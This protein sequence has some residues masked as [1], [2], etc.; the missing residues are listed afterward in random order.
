MTD[1][2]PEIRHSHP[3]VMYDM[4]K[5]IPK[6]IDGT[7]KK[8]EPFEGKNFPEPLI[9]TG[10]GTAYHSAVLG[11]QFL[12]RSGVKWDH[13]QAYELMHYREP[14][15]SIMAFS[16]TGKTKSTVDV[17]R[18][19]RKK[20][21]TVGITHYPE[22]PLAQEAHVAF[23]IGN[24]P[25]ASLCNTKAFF[26]NVFAS[27]FISNR[28]GNLGLDLK[29]YR[30]AISREIAGKEERVRAIVKDLS[31]TRDI[32]VLGAGPNYIAAREA[33]QKM[34]E[35]TH[36]HAEGIELEEFNHGCTAV[37]DEN[38]TVFII[39]GE[40]DEERTSDIVRACREVGTRT[41]VLNS[42]GDY[43]IDVDFIG[44]NL[45]LPIISMVDL[46]YFAYF[47]AVERGINPD[48]LRF[49]DKRYLNFDSIVFPPGT[50]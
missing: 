3:Y 40:R 32:F 19:Y 39:S 17:V 8:M 12:S 33:A 26:D 36:L 15:G 31:G 5:D 30:N 10:N 25:D 47:M 2:L 35:S 41:V 9:F 49:E 23:V 44:D 1:E 4:I 38:T 16:H 29:A 50:H 11:A 42:E 45:F 27:L 22:S 13:V 7:L 46:Y 18:Y 14:Q 43:A 34:K 28:I 24:G 6:G 37:I 21:Q 20:L 48:Y